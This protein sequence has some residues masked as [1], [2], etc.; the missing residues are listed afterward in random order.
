M[1]YGRPVALDTLGVEKRLGSICGRNPYGLKRGFP[2]LGGTTP[3]AVRS[4]SP[5]WRRASTVRGSSRAARAAHPRSIHRRRRTASAGRIPDTAT[6]ENRA[7]ATPPAEAGPA[8]TRTCVA[9]R[10]YQVN[11]GDSSIDPLPRR[12]RIKRP[13]NVPWLGRSRTGKQSY[14]PWRARGMGAGVVT[15]VP[16]PCGRTSWERCPEA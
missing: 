3:V 10:S 9:S 1:V 16:A 8:A 4:D 5:V 12:P 6:S 14:E 15:R 7:R 11:T 2:P 13:D